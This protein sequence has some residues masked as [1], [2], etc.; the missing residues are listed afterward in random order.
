MYLLKQHITGKIK[1]EDEKLFASL[2]WSKT[3]VQSWNFARINSDEHD[4]VN[5]T[6]IPSEFTSHIDHRQSLPQGSGSSTYTSNFAAVKKE[7]DLLP[8]HLHGNLL[9]LIYYSGGEW[10]T[11][12]HFFDSWYDMTAGS[13]ISWDEYPAGGITTATKDR[14]STSHLRLITLFVLQ[15]GT[16]NVYESRLE[17]ML[18]K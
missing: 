6:P 18:S 17:E 12:K 16:N 7:P 10:R 11:K 14:N 9:Q 4:H 15:R 3:N 5:K 13:S 2:K 8:C 1:E